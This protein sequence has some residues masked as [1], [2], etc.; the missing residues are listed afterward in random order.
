MIAIVDY[1]TCNTG[2]I[3]N[4][5]MRIGAEAVVATSPEPLKT[6][7]RIILPGVGSFDTGISYL[8]AGGFVE[9]LSRRVL[10]DGVPILG[11]CLGAQLF[12]KESEEG[13]EPGLGWIDAVTKRFRFPTENLK[14]PHMGWNRTRATRP[15]PLFE[16]FEHDPRFYFVHS[17]FLNCASPDNVLAETHHGFWFA[18]AVGKENIVG[19]QFHPEKS[20]RFGLQLLRNFV[21]G[22][23]VKGAG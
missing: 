9:V 2:S 6:A 11:V 4:M 8:R 14:V 18:S 1:G 17:Y 21:C 15:S 16:N 22:Q 19:V 10:E 7:D 20:H 13:N 3:M 12:S 23:F 5:L